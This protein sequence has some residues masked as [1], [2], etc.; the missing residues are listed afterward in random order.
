MP[1][2][3]GCS[4]SSQLTLN[5][6]NLSDTP[7]SL[8]WESCSSAGLAGTLAWLRRVT[9]ARV[10]S[11]FRCRSWSQHRYPS[12]LSSQAPW[13]RLWNEE[14]PVSRPALLLIPRLG[15]RASVNGLND[16][17][18]ALCH[19]V[20]LL[21]VKNKEKKKISWSVTFTAV[22][23]WFPHIRERTSLSRGLEHSY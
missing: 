8:V 4:R 1:V 15:L 2:R 16:G 17:G 12:P 3:A 23:I 18:T 11:L 21:R 5:A 22:E 7:S 14:R 13:P 10:K 6:A 9:F 20:L 19:F